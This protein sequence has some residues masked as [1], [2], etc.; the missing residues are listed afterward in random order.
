MH[1]L[2]YM[3]VEVILHS[4]FSEPAF[5][6]WPRC[7]MKSGAVPS[8]SGMMSGLKNFQMLEDLEFSE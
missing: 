4:S 1:T 2:L 8:T 5:G 3:Y 7:H 6:R